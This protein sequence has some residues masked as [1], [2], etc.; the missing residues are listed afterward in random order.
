MWP[1]WCCCGCPAYIKFVGCPTIGECDASAPVIFVSEELSCEDTNEP[2]WFKTIN[3]PQHPDLTG[4]CW[5]NGD[6][7]R[8]HCEPGPPPPGRCRLPPGAILIDPPTVVVCVLNCDDEACAPRGNY[9]VP[10]ACSPPCGSD[11]PVLVCPGNM[12]LS[13]CWHSRVPGTEDC[14]CIVVGPNSKPFTGDPSGYLIIDSNSVVWREADNPETACCECCYG[15]PNGCNYAPVTTG[16]I[17]HPFCYKNPDNQQPV[18]CCCGDRWVLV[19]IKRRRSRSMT[20][21][22]PP[23]NYLNEIDIRMWS[24]VVTEWDADQGLLGCRHAQGRALQIDRFGDLDDGDPTETRQEWNVNGC[25]D[26]NMTISMI[27]WDGCGKSANDLASGVSP[28]CYHNEGANAFNS[29]FGDWTT[30][31]YNLASCNGSADELDCGDK[32]CSGDF[33]MRGGCNLNRFVGKYSENYTNQQGVR[34]AFDSEW[35]A[36]TLVLVTNQHQGCE[37]GCPRRA[38]K[39][40]NASGASV[41][42]IGTG[43]IGAGDLL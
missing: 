22:A 11:R 35:V 43:M 36:F 27:A 12:D 41:D 16:D 1:F 4:W 30:T 14:G 31:Y 21:S 10:T 26:P 6:P 2:L 17:E 9:I 20:I 3:L 5:L 18:P 32:G 33:E 40:K 37:G 8:Y 24:I 34:F 25:D 29:W 39:V 15:C 23:S 13:K 38:P 19:S 28:F 42:P 7:C